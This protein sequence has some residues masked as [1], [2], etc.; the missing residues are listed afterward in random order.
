[1]YGAL[2]ATAQHDRKR[3]VAYSSFSHLGFVLPGIFDWNAWALRGVVIQMIAHGI[4]TG[5]L[6]IL[7]GLL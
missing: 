4:S 3:L 6:F 5:A 2:L 1:M 7:V